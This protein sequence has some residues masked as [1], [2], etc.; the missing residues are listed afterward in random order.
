MQRTHINKP[1]TLVELMVVIGIIAIIMGISV[2]A[3]RNI[4]VG[5]GV[6]AASR[7]LSSQLMLARAEAIARRRHVA[8]IIPGQYYEKISSDPSIYNFT[9]FRSAFVNVGSGTD[10]LFD[11]WVPGT[12]WTFLP[13]GSLI[14]ILETTSTSSPVAIELSGTNYIPNTSNYDIP[15]DTATNGKG[16]G[17]DASCTSVKDDTDNGKYMEDNTAQNSTHGIRAIVFKPNGRCVQKN[18]L[19]IMEGVVETASNTT[20]RLNRSNVHVMEVNQYPGQVRYLY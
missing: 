17:C 20:T 2:P 9:S 12:Q 11:E 7:M 6:N 18:Y 5:S 8:V 13:T 14:R 19:T 4:T 15:S 10:Y 3:F 1:F 16:D